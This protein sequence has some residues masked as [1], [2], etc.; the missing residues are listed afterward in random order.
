MKSPGKSLFTLHRLVHRAVSIRYKQ[1]SFNV[2]LFRHLP[3]L[4]GLL[5]QVKDELNLM[6]LSSCRL[7][8][9]I[10]VRRLRAGT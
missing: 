2:S 5:T 10:G 4:R 8:Y 1:I 7:Q 3:E 9:G 6:L